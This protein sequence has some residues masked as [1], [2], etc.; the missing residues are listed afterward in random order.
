MWN[1]AQR[2]QVRHGNGQSGGLGNIITLV[3]WEEDA[4]EGIKYIRILLGELPMRK[5]GEGYRE[6]WES[7]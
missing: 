5:N 1:T 2:Q 7:H 3:P 4:Q 6:G